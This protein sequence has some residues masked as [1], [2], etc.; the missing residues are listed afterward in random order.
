MNSDKH[1][2][3]ALQDLD[4]LIDSLEKHGRFFTFSKSGRRA[5]FTRDLDANALEFV[6]DKR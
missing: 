6:E 3:I 2:A 5:V 1:V 4:P